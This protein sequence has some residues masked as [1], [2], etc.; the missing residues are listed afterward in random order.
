LAADRLLGLAILAD[1]VDGAPYT[2]E[3][4]D[5]LQCIGNLAAAGLLNLR[6]SEELVLAKQLE[7][8]QT[9]AAFFVHD[10]KNVV[11][12]LSLTLDNLSVH[13]DDP[14]F[15][16]DALRGISATVTRINHLIGRMSVLRNRTDVKPV[17]SDL[18]QLV[19]EA[20][21]GLNWLREVELVKE[22]HPLPKILADPE[23]LQNV[24][25]N[26]LL[27][28]RE[29]VGKGGQVRVQTGQQDG[30]AVLT[31]AD[32]GCGMS[33]VFLRDSLY[34]PFHTTKKAGLGIGLFQSRMIVEAHRGSIQAESDL[35]KGT[36]FLVILPL[37]REQSSVADPEAAGNG[38][39]SSVLSPKISQ[40]TRRLPGER[41]A[42]SA[43]GD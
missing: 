23:R 27:N 30:H 26:L 39:E 6:L 10:L 16:Q 32:N 31:V 17:E 5:L 15:R 20:L 4:L 22:L 2:P 40:L 42:I 13:F 25:T 28:A 21:A 41:R 8:F 18:N 11:S 19:L 24:V 3:E 37:P 1:R 7:A 43:T 38:L 12:G 14:S 33:P 35:G 34:R 9:M 36:T 29:A